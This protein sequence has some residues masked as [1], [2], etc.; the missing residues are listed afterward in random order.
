[1]HTH[2]NTCIMHVL[3]WVCMRVTAC[4]SLHRI[5][6][7]IPSEIENPGTG[8]EG[9]SKHLH[10]GTPIWGRQTEPESVRQG[11]TT[12]RWNADH[13]I[14]ERHHRSGWPAS[15]STF[16]QRPYLLYLIHVNTFA[17]ILSVGVLMDPRGFS[18]VLRRPQESSEFPRVLSD[19]QGSSVVLRGPPRLSRVFRPGSS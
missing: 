11:R 1:M 13:R 4:H 16:G 12:E 6:G 2:I 7:R 10:G 3:M 15:Q 5:T 19:P 9:Q 17:S 8:I 18:G 14:R